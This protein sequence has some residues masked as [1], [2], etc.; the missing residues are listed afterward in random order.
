MDVCGEGLD[1]ELCLVPAMPYYD[2]SLFLAIELNVAD[3][4]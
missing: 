4:C 1:R 3:D 2:S